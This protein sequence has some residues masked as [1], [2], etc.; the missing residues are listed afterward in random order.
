MKL[1]AILLMTQYCS[2]IVRSSSNDFEWLTFSYNVGQSGRLFTQQY[3][4][5]EYTYFTFSTIVLNNPVNNLSIK[6]MQPR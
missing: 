2:L 5:Y 4:K 6:Y 3:L 1:I